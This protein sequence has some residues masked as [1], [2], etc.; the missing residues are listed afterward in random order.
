MPID[1]LRGDPAAV[2]VT[3]TTRN[4]A[5]TYIGRC[6]DKSSAFRLAKTVNVRECWSENAEYWTEMQ[7]ISNGKSNLHR[8]NIV[9]FIMIHLKTLPRDSP[10]SNTKH[11]HTHCLGFLDRC[12]MYENT[13]D[14]SHRDSNRG[15]AA[16]L[17]TSRVK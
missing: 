16:P 14:R 5:I 4:L 13:S 10:C 15:N 8:Y 11:T 9:R 12:E 1:S 17:M 7:W 3:E 6:D 2:N